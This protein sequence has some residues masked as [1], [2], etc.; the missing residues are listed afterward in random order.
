M[1]FGPLFG[2]AEPDETFLPSLTRG[3]AALREAVVRLAAHTMLLDAPGAYGPWGAATRQKL[4]LRLG[5]LHAG[6]TAIKRDGIRLDV[7]EPQGAIYLSVRLPLAGRKWKGETIRTNEQIRKL[8]LEDALF[9]IVPFHAFGLREE[10]GWLRPSVGAVSP[11]QIASAPPRVAS[12][13]SAA[14]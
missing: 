5:A 11:P 14:R 1:S 3:L 9:P 12:M 2:P 8:L 6:L 13:L 7:V 10:T 4:K